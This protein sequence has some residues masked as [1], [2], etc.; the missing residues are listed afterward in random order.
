MIKKINLLNYFLIKIALIY[1]KFFLAKEEENDNKKK[2]NPSTINSISGFN[3]SNS[4]QYFS[5]IS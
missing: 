1:L 4:N 3:E 5:K 2:N